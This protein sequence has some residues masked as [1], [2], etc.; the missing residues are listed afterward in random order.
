MDWR[1]NLIT[2]DHDIIELAGA[3]KRVAVLG[4]RSEKFP[5]RPAFY[6]AEYLFEAGLDV[7]PVPV[8]E[9]DV[10]RILDADVYRKVADVPGEIDIL[11]VFRRSHD[12]PPHL[13]D[14]LEKNPRAVWFQLGIRNDAAAKTLA[15]AGIKVIQDRCLMVDH[16]RAT[17]MRTRV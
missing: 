8:Y 7:V 12:I 9:L 15:K 6:V 13:P 16:R 1:N 17:M 10:T 4:I 5:Y 3:A 14:I 2:N 11:D